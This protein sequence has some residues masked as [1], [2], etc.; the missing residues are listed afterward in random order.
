MAKVYD[1]PAD[2]LIQRLA[3]V[4]KGEDIP[5]PSWIPFVK[6]GA[7]ATNPPQDR[8]WW[9]SRCASIMRK[10][11]LYGPIGI[12]ELR[13]DYGGGKPSGYGA[14]HHKDAGGA[15]IRG[16]VHRLEQLGYVVK[17]EKKGRVISSTGMQKLDRLSTEILKEMVSEN[18]QLKVY[19]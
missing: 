14:A 4:L 8:D 5:A 9:Y 12:N 13:K 17:A 15:I 7:H 19:T 1:V 18:P 2:A 6:T 10:I 3:Q 16:A 11:Y